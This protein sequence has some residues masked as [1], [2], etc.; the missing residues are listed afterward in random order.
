MTLDA[1]D[2][3]FVHRWRSCRMPQPPA[4]NPRPA[5][6]APA[7]PDAAAW[8]PTASSPDA[9]AEAGQQ[10]GPCLVERLLAAALPQWNA[11]ADRV[12]AARA[13]GRRVIAIAGCERGEGRTT[14][15]ATL[16]RVLRSRQREVEAVEP[17]ELPIAAGVTCDKRIILVDAGVWFPPGPI[18]RQRLMVASHG[19]EAALIVRRADSPPV[20][21][22]EAALEAIGVEPLGEVVTFARRT[23]A[24][25]TEA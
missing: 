25:E 17:G 11:V 10:A 3:A 4:L 8:P 23:A 22:I 14:L 24:E 15:V 5:A 16:A 7:A 9:A 18:R 1:L 20:V 13:R 2:A 21:A 19:C 6:S 12:E